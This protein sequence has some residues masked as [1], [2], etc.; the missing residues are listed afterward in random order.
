M[1]IGLVSNITK[2][3]DGSITRSFIKAV[4]DRGMN[5]I[6]YPSIRKYFIESETVNESEFYSESDIII[7]LG[8]DGTLLNTAR[9]AALF[10]KPI[11]GIN[12][13]RLGFLTEAEI[14]DSGN[15]LDALA[16]GNFFIESR[17]MVKAQLCRNGSVIY[18]NSALN[19]I[20]I[21]KGSFARIIHL[22]AY[23]NDEYAGSYSADG[24][25]VSSPTGSTAYSLS[26]GGPVIQPGVMCLLLTPIC[27]HSLNSRPIITDFNAQIKIVVSDTNRDILLTVD[28][29]EGT[30]LHE[31]DII[32]VTKSEYETRLIRTKNYNFFKILR[33]KLTER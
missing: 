32:Y 8:G 16:A 11:L 19:E 18:S 27:A 28:G 7:V 2:D 25:L 20:A 26:A 10:H 12:L 22:D 29:Q 17:M 14:S 31:G 23:I 9:Q 15:I 1:K 6:V 3:T 24:L 5:I 21:A 4:I 30:E 33:N 13:G